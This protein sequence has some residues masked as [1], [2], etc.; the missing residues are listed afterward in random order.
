MWDKFLH[1]LTLM[2]KHHV[3]SQ[4]MTTAGILLAALIIIKVVD[5][6]LARWQKKIIINLRKV[7]P[8]GVSS[9]ETKVTIIRKLFNAFVYFL[10]FA[11]FLFQ[12][13][14]IR[15]IGTGLLASAGLAGIIIGMAAQNTL[16]NIICGI[17]ISFS[18]PVR[19]G[20]A[21]IFRNE[22]G[23]IEEISL[24]HT[25]IVTWDNRRIVVP[26]NVMAN[27]VIENWTIKDPSLLGV[28]MVYADYTCDVDKV[29][30]WVKEIID[31]SS[32]S[33]NERVAVVQVTD[34]TEKSMVLR[35]LGKSPDAP[36]AWNLRCEIREKLIEKFKEE[37][38]PLPQIRINSE[39]FQA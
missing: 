12:F 7:V 34:F 32:Y 21:V 8:A 17:S 5:L 33:T 3:F 38:M 36:S 10:A 23:W 14:S 26:N 18:E 29:K 28:V 25:V 30:R 13:E 2:S 31:A 4:I 39:K 22:F 6:L 27:E 35:I 11:L 19:L 24:M 16:S 20:D 1:N 15:H 37:K 9:L